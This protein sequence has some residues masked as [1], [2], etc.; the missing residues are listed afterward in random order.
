[1]NT[2]Y[3]TYSNTSCTSGCHLYHDGT[4]NSNQYGPY[5]SVTNAN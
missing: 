3:S 4:C 2:R 1:V 5:P